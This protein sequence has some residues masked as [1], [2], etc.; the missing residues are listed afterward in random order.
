MCDDDK[1]AMSS[2]TESKSWDLKLKIKDKKCK[3]LG[4][5]AV[6][7]AVYSPLSPDAPPMC[8]TGSSQQYE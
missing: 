1:R 7:I 4:Y 2:L 6:H 5:L 8:K 3:T